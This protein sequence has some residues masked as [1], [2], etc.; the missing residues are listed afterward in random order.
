MCFE[1]EFQSLKMCFDP[2]DLVYPTMYYGSKSDSFDV[3]FQI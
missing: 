1:F 3:T 2:I